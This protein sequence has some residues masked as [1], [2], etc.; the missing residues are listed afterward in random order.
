MST[1]LGLTVAAVVLVLV[2]MTLSETIRKGDLKAAW[3]N[4][5]L[6]WKRV[7]RS[8]GTYMYLVLA[9]HEIT[10]YADPSYVSSPLPRWARIPMGVAF[11]SWA[12]RRIAAD[13]LNSATVEVT[14]TKEKP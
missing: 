3:A 7:K 9:I 14:I 10:A 1:F 12:I 13:V 4:R 2:L 8:A 11:L 6:G 5:A